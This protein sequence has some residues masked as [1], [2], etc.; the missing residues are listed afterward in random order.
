MVLLAVTASAFTGSPNPVV[1]AERA[2][3][4]LQSVGHTAEPSPSPE[5]TSD[6]SRKTPAAPVEATHEPESEPK[7]APEPKESPE[8]REGPEAPEASSRSEERSGD[9]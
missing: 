6:A 3:S 5:P 2:G 8:P 1:W 4:T 7:E 9:H